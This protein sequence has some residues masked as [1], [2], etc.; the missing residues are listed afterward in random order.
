MHAGPNHVLKAGQRDWCS[1]GLA[2]CTAETSAPAG[3]GSAHLKA[4][5]QKSTKW[6]MLA[7]WVKAPLSSNHCGCTKWCSVTFGCIPCLPTHT[8]WS[9]QGRLVKL[10][11]QAPHPSSSQAGRTASA[12]GFRHAQTCTALLTILVRVTGIYLEG[13]QCHFLVALDLTYLQ[14]EHL[15]IKVRSSWGLQPAA[16]T[17]S[18]LQQ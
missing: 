6:G 7:S 16:V 12:Q 13:I 15:C 17:F 11:S 2:A 4:R 3:P 18:P 10:Q 1:A 14:L 9:S 8:A 5:E